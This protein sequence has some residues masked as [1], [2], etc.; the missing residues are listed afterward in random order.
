M[1]LDSGFD[2]EK[3]KQASTH[4]K[5]WGAKLIA[6]LQLSGAESIL[7]LGCGDGAL[8]VQLASLV[9]RGHVIG[10]DFSQ[11]MIETAKRQRQANLTFE[12]L[13]M[14]ELAYEAKFDL[15][16]SNATLHWIADHRNLLQ[17]VFRSLKANGAVRFSFAADGNCS[18]FNR[19][20]Q[21]VMSRP[22]YAPYF[23]GFAWPWYMP[24]VDDYRRLLSQFPFRE[25]SVWGENADRFFPDAETMIRWIDQPGLVPFVARIE[26]TDRT[27]FR[28]EVIAGMIQATRQSDGRC[29]ETFRRVNVF[30]RR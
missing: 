30:A 12:L 23:T 8:T 10:I 7:D 22:K 6:E 11:S 19:V 26:G 18:N 4:Q 15:V 21:E 25:V 17:R 16:F 28:E 27:S 3:Y 9:P 24:Q 13:D 5:E 29:F 2:G 20:V 1:A 14:N